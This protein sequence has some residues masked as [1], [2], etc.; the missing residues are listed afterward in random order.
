MTANPQPA[1]LAR[2]PNHLSYDGPGFLLEKDI[3]PGGLPGDQR[4]SILRSIISREKKESGL[5]AVTKGKGRGSFIR[6]IEKKIADLKWEGVLSTGNDWE[7]YN[8]LNCGRY[9]ARERNLKGDARDVV[10]HCN[11]MRMCPKC[12]ERYYLGRSYDRGRIAEVVMHANNVE[13]LR[14]YNL[15]FPDFIRDQIKNDDE[16]RVFERA[17]NRMFQEFYGCPMDCHGRYKNGS[18]GVHI[19][20]HWYSSKECGR[21]SPHFHCYVIAVKVEKGKAQNVDRWFFEIDKR[22]LKRAW[23]DT[24]RKMCRKLGFNEIERIPDDVV[25]EYD[26]INLEKNLKKKGHP[27]FNFKYDQRSPVQDLEKAV[28]GMDFDKE[29][30]IMTF[31]QNGYDYYAIWSFDDYAAEMLKKL[32]LKRTN[33]TYGW[34]RRF[35]QNAETLGVEVKEEKDDFDPVPELAVKTEYRRE[36]EDKYNKKKGKVETVTRMSVKILTDPDEPEFWKEVDPWKVHGE[37]TW[38]GSKKRYAYSIAKDRR[39]IDRGG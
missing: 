24:L 37:M 31:N 14:K 13:Y 35:R 10:Y 33:S 39:P 2:V 4:R 7:R 5:R 29:L 17:A 25:I 16:M 8:Y 12:S 3:Y 19:Q 36:Y 27:G 26:A 32:N 6:R 11:R 34:L 18:V 1:S 21:K 38:T 28:V 15:T 9:G 23:A 30:V 22:M 20:P